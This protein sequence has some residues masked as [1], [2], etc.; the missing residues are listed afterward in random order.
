LNIDPPAAEIFVDV[1]LLRHFYDRFFINDPPEADLK[2]SIFKLKYS[3]IGN[4]NPEIFGFRIFVWLLS[5]LRSKPAP[6]S[7]ADQPILLGNNLFGVASG[8][9]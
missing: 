1:A 7:Q 2:Y 9:F 4:K 8:R 6:I 5:R 3:I